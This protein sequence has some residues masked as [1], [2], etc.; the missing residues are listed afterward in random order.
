[1]DKTARRQELLYAARE[2]FATKGYHDAKIDDIVAAA[3]V[4]KGTFY[5]YFKD[6]RSIFSELVDGFFTRIGGAILKVD[7]DADVEAQVK[8][9]IRAIVAVLLDDPLLAQILLSYAAGLDAAFVAKIK[10]FYDGAKLLLREALAEGQRLGIVAEGDTALYS[11]FTIGA[12][13]EVILE[14]ALSQRVRPREEIVTAMFELLQS[15]YL[16][17][18]PAPR[19]ASVRP[20]G[21]PT[22]SGRAP[23]Q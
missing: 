2:V 8:H 9:N 1:V 19:P 12:L 18:A 21:A 7:G 22:R 11:T 23:A 10:S 13:K 4:A 15:G 3:K 16:R 14:Q 20:R 6:K 17:I 5:L